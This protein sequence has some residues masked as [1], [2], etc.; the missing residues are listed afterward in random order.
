MIDLA[1]SYS[2]IIER[3][4]KAWNCENLMDRSQSPRTSK[5]PFS[6]PMMNYATYGGVPRNAMIEFYGEPSGGKSTTSIDICKSACS[7]FQKEF[8]DEVAS[9]QK[10]VSAGNKS[11]QGEL[12]D[13][14]ERGPKKVLYLDL[15]HSFDSAW[16]ATIGIT[17]SAIDIMQPPDVV[18]E[19][20][21]ETLLDIIATG[22]IG[23]IVLDSIPS[24]VPRAVLEKKIGERTVA[25]LA[26][27]MTV[28]CTKVIPLL[29]RYQTTLILINQI[30]ANMDNPYV[31]KTPGGEAIKFYSSLRI[32]FKI[33]T[34]VD[35]L[36][37]ELPMNTED[38]AGYIINAKLT[39]QKSAPHDRKNATYYLM[40]RSGIRPDFDYAKL[41]VT[42]YGI[43]HKAG[44]W[45]TISDPYTGEVLEDGGKPVK[46]NGMA[47]VY[48]FLKMNPEYYQKL[49]DF[50][51]NDISGTPSNSTDAT[52]GG[53]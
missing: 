39:K 25:S 43:I 6:S 40:T 2:S 12:A 46:V 14:Q 15:E 33:G 24:L 22:E 5:I 49:K 8:D 48:D 1:D 35:F 50:I 9:L 18:A 23:L 32:Y 42:K 10:F 47:K 31:P 36:G 30:R 3:C 51:W 37:N 11:A 38:P 44:A 4:K 27:L 29:T 28:F 19:D 41:A 13:L 17:D 34:P 26:G 52:E 53:L 7:I 16:A 21:L 45:F 20:I